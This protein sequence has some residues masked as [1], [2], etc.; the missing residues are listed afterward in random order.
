[1]L[2][3]SSLGF[4]LAPWCRQHRLEL[5]CWRMEICDECLSGR[6]HGAQCMGEEEALRVSKCHDLDP[7]EAC[8]AYGDTHE[9]EAMLALAHKHDYCG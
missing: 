7:Y 9:D 3:L 5:I 4:F 1:M 6:Y 8:Y 2:A